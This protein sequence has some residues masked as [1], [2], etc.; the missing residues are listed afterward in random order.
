MLESLYL[1]KLEECHI[2]TFFGLDNLLNLCYSFNR[3]FCSHI[4]KSMR[5]ASYN[6]RK[7]QILAY[8]CQCKAMTSADLASAF[9]ISLQDASELLRRY[10]NQGY[11]R[12]HRDRHK[13][14]PPKAFIYRISPRGEAR[15]DGI[16]IYNSVSVYDHTQCRYVS[17][18]EKRR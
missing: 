11:L 4:K 9:G 6:E 5:K 17:R 8:V 7:A 10:H 3:C 16:E 2:F 12:R 15:R 14:G 18:F 13:G 1:G